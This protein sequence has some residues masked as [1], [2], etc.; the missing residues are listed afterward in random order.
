M[1]LEVFEELLLP[2]D[3]NRMNRGQEREVT[4]TDKRAERQRLWEQ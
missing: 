2:G 3:Q 4:R 1:I